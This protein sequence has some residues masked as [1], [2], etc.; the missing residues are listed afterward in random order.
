[1]FCLGMILG[2][3]TTLVVQDVMVLYKEKST[4]RKNDDKR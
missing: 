1:M 4:R 3:F 2:H